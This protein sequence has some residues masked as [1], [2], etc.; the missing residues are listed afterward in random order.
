MSNVHLHVLQEGIYQNL[1][2]M[3]KHQGGKWCFSEPCFCLQPANT[4]LGYRVTFMSCPSVRLHH[5][6]AT[7]Q[8]RI[9]YTMP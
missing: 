9:R 2:N 1:V 6:S 8:V 5:Y 4:V 3:Y 7:P